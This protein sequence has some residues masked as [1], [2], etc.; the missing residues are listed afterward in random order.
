VRGAYEGHMRGVR[1][2]D[3]V[4]VGCVGA[5]RLP[6]E[7]TG[8]SSIAPGLAR[9][10]GPSTNSAPIL[11]GLSSTWLDTTVKVSVA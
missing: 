10:T 8:V 6:M 4:R 11:F 9:I 1:G 5:Y 3:G 2:A 7:C